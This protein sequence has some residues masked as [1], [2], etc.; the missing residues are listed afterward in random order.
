MTVQMFSYVSLGADL[1]S[2][3]PGPGFRH[4]TFVQSIDTLCY[5]QHQREPDREVAHFVPSSCR[6]IT[7]SP[8]RLCN[9]SSV[10][11]AFGDLP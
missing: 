3:S 6:R 5:P 1:H 7:D 9:G 4:N 8:A 11:S 10:E 2:G